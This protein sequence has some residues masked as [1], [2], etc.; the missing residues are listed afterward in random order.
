MT[1]EISYG[2]ILERE[3][4]FQKLLN[5]LD[6]KG[7]GERLTGLEKERLPQSHQAMEWRKEGMRRPGQEVK[8]GELVAGRTH[9]AGKI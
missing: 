5:R 6:L 2:L 1:W 7:Y 9:M 3:P 4:N 8:R